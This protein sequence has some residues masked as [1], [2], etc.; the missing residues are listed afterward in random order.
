MRSNVIPTIY[1]AVGLSALFG[2]PLIFNYARQQVSERQREHQQQRQKL[3]QQ[4]YT[5]A[6]KNNNNYLEQEE[7]SELGRELNVTFPAGGIEDIINFLPDKMLE[8]Y[9]QSHSRH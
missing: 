4:V 6:D 5:I 1:L 9:V 7:L 2:L 3:E 8:N